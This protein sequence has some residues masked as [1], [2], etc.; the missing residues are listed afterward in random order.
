MNLNDLKKMNFNKLMKNALINVK[1]QRK[2]KK[3]R[4]T[5]KKS[6]KLNELINRCDD[7]E[8]M[9]L[10]TKNSY[11]LNY[12]NVDIQSLNRKREADYHKN[13]KKMIKTLD[14][15]TLTVR[16]VVSNDVSSQSFFNSA[17]QNKINQ[18]EEYVFESRINCLY[19]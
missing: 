14:A 12:F 8:N 2:L 19:C 9:H 7:R 16:A 13:L 1:T 17:E 5:D 4:N 6:D 3:I 15:M 10:E 11:R 18:S